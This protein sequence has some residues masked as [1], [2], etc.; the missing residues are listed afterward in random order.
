M[1]SALLWKPTNC[2]VC[3]YLINKMLDKGQVQYT[4]EE[5]DDDE[6]IKSQVEVFKHFQLGSV[7][8]CVFLVNLITQ[9][10]ILE[11]LH[12]KNGKQSYIPMARMPPCIVLC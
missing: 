12:G 7:C 8:V 1:S 2:S 5:D 10:Q 4:Q 9:L 3:T 6:R 11:Q